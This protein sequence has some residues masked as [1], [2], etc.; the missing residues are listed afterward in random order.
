MVA[1]VDMGGRRGNRTCCLLETMLW[2]RL[3][4]AASN[5]ALTVG[6]SG[7]QKLY[8][9]ARLIKESSLFMS[10]TFAYPRQ[11]GE[12]YWIL[13]SILLRK[14]ECKRG[15]ERACVRKMRRAWRDWLHEEV[16]KSTCG[17]ME[18]VDEM[19]MPNIVM[20]SARWMLGMVGG[21]CALELVLRKRISTDLALLSFKLL[22][23]DH[24]SMWDSSAGVV[25]IWLEGMIRYVSSANLLMALPGVSG[26]RSEAAIMNAAGPTAEPWTTE[27]VIW[28]WVDSSP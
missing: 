10:S 12:Q 18:R 21:S 1:A 8:F 4:S 19:V 23:V 26:R 9:L 13:D 14:T 28:R 25:C 15:S 11:A 27:A 3:S 16:R 20:L 7:E 24:C 17:E 6:V 5:K 22:L 2:K